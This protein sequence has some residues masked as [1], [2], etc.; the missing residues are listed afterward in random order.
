VRSTDRWRWQEGRREAV[1]LAE[2]V[3]VLKGRRL[4]VVGA[5][6]VLG[7]VAL[8]LGLMREPSYTAEAVAG[9]EPGEASEDENANKAFAQ[10]VL[11]S[12]TAS[13]TFSED[14]RN[15]AGWSDTPKEFRDRLVGAEA[16]V[17]E[18]G[19]MR[20]RVRFAGRGPEEAARVA[21]A[22]AET[23]ALEAERL[24]GGQLSGGTSVA[25]ARVTQR[26]VPSDGSGPGALV[27]AAVAAGVGLLVGG[28][29]ALLLEGRAGGWRGVQD[30]E[31]TLKAPVLGAIPD[32]SGI[33]SPA[34]NEG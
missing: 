1:S 16:F 30:A 33:E 29:A 25:G 27:Y 20:M 14:V 2:I 26:A 12:V 28:V 10:E 24:G 23:F 13:Q 9:F 22:Y 7:A 18:D 15:R 6:L 8:M 32:Y 31:I 3:H 19:G 4:L 11:S 21:N 5:V 34:E 17:S